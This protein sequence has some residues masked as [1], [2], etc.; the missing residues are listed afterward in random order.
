[1][2]GKTPLTYL[3]SRLLDRHP[4]EGI[5][6]IEMEIEEKKWKPLGLLCV[7]NFDLGSRFLCI[8]HATNGS[9]QATLVGFFEEVDPFSL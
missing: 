6:R 5:K 4:H 3:W 9:P 8:R 2:G 1:M 7:C